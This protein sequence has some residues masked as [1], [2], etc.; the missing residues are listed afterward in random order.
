MHHS[1]PDVV[2]ELFLDKLLAIV[3]GIEDFT[4][5]QRRGGV[6]TNQAEAFLQLCRNWIL[7][8]EQMKWFEALP[9]ARCFDR[10][11][12]VMG[13]MQQVNF[14]SELLAKPFEQE[15]REVQV[16]LGAPDIFRR[17]IFFRWLVIHF[18]AAHSVRAFQPGNA[19]L[20][21]N[22]FVS[23]FEV[24]GD[25]F[26]GLLDVPPAGMSVNENAIAGSASQQ[27]IDGR[28]QRLALDVPE[29]RVNGGNRAHGDRA[30]APVRAL[31]KVLPEVLN[32]PCI[33][34]DEKW[35]DVVGEVTG[36]CEFPAVQRG[37]PQAV[38]PVFCRNLQRYEIPARTANNHFGIGDSH[39]WFTSLVALSSKSRK[40][41]SS[42][43]QQ[44]DK[45]TLMKLGGYMRAELAASRR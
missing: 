2:D 36:N 13:I 17:S 5:G 34:P 43:S 28:V 45:R 41:R 25:R 11:E 21:A 26:D 8:P 37:I 19:A 33:A 29:R 18:A 15:R 22:R 12:P 16:Q 40:K 32:S 27:L 44:A 39:L 23:K 14:R 7:E 9:Q 24:V 3:N 20:R 38:D 31:I 35:N 1:S 6:L 4:H 42:L 10:C 30:T